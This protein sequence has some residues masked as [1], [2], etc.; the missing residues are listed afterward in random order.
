MAADVIAQGEFLYLGS[1]LK[2]LAEQLQGDVVR[3]A[4]AAGVP[5]QP[6]QYPLLATLEAGAASI[7]EIAQA[8]RMSQPAITRNVDR[9]VRSGLVDVLPSRADR[10]QRVVSLSIAGREALARAKTSVSP[11]VE[12]AVR[13]LA[14][15]LSGPLLE[16]IATLESRLAE[17]SLGERI[18]AQGADRLERA[19]DADIP[20]IVTLMNAAYRGT[21]AAASWCSEADFIAGDRT[22]AAWLRAEIAANSDAALMVWRRADGAIQGSVW[23]E[24]KGEGLWYLGSLAIDP[25]VQNSGLGRRLLALAEAR[26]AAQGGREVMMNVINIRESLIAWYER[27][28]YRPCGETASFPY[29]DDRFGI[30]KRGDLY[31]VTLRKSLAEPACTG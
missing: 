2:R 26:I 5:I 18:R 28:G 17:R 4:N 29:G 9:L 31:F 11:R 19:M 25:G 13:A 8:M 30:P 16:Q 20:A 23:L 1:R 6:G 21:G 22:N 27:R 10:R 3:A 24:P 14:A 12:E 7:G 15:D